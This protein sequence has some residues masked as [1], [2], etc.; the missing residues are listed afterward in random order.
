MEAKINDKGDSGLFFRSQFAKAWPKGY[1]AQINVISPIQT[2]S[3]FSG[4]NPKLNDDEKKK[5]TVVKA[6]HKPDEWFTYEVTADGNYLILKVN[7]KTT[8]DFQ[9]DN[10]TYTKGHFGIQHNG[11]ENVITVRKLE[12]KPLP[13]KKK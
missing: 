11:P 3:L 6:P 5:I 10:F 1:E 12:V 8:A 2:G 13:P 4:F 9:D 7:G